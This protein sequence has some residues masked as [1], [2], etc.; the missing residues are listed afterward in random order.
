[1]VFSRE[2]L[3]VL[4]NSASLK[5][6]DSLLGFL[7]VPLVCRHVP[8]SDPC[9]GDHS[10]FVVCL[11]SWVVMPLDLFFVV[12]VQDYFHYSFCFVILYEFC[13]FFSQLPL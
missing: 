2:V 8:I 4:E 11:E 1:M 3:G 12:V 10:R 6:V 7:S 13:G 9:I 5:Y